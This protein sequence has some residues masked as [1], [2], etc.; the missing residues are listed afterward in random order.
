MPKGT[1][2][3]TSEFVSIL[4]V[5][6]EYHIIISSLIIHD[7]LPPPEMRQSFEIPTFICSNFLLLKQIT[8]ISITQVT[9]NFPIKI[10]KS[11]CKI[12]PT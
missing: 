11:H 5:S 3:N 6:V 7:L 12:F 9:L 2:I 4:E 8:C 10:E 1:T